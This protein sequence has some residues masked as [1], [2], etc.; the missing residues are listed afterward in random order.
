[1]NKKIL[2]NDPLLLSISIYL[3]EQNVLE[4]FYLVKGW[5]PFCIQTFRK[6]NTINRY[7]PTALCEMGDIPKSFACDALGQGSE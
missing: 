3:E 1:M 4:K 5:K 6:K 7:C 2:K